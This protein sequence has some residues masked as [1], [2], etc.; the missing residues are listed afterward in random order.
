[1]VLGELDIYTQ[2]NEIE[3]LPNTAYKINW[4]WIYD[5]N[6]KPKTIKLLEENP[7]QKLP[8]VGLGNDFLDMTPK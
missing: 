6:V 5:L 3:P 7:G 1:M 8:K 4:K 2:K